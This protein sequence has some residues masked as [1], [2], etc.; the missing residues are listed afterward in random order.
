MRKSLSYGFKALNLA[1]K[2]NGFYAVLAILSKLYDSTIYPLIQVLLLSI[3]LDLLAQDKSLT[4]FNLGWI[5]VIY[6]LASLVKLSLKSFLDVKEA[7]LQ[8]QQE[9]YIDLLISKKL[10]ELDPATFEN[11]EFQDLLAQLD[12]IKGTLQMHLVR[13]T[14]LID[15][16]FK[17]ITAT[18]I[19]SF[20]FPLFA[21]LIIIAT[22]PSYIT[23]DRFRVKTWPYYVEKK[24]IVTRVTQYIKNLLSS[25]STSKEAI[26]FQTGPVLLSKI[27]KEQKSYFSEFAKANDPWI[28][29]ILLA[30]VLQFGVFAYTQY[31]NL[32]RVLQGTLSIGQFTLVF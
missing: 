7:F 26:I 1:W 11:P 20:T 13:F 18:V 23:W 21:P 25:D 5:I 28:I 3:L 6:L 32:S 24:S 2:A 27:K 29:N 31:L 12:G 22:I 15:A 9:G 4:L 19:L 10:T 17:F 14:S 30:R 8:T 16:V